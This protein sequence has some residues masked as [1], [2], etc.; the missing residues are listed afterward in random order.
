MTAQS[1]TAQASAYGISMQGGGGENS[2]TIQASA[3]SDDA[4]ALAYGILAFNGSSAVSL[5]NSGTISAEATGDDGWAYGIWADSRSSVSITNSGTIS[6]YG[7]NANI[8]LL[9]SGSGVNRVVNTGTIQTSYDAME[10]SIGIA[11]NGPTE[12]VNTGIIDTG[13]DW[14]G[15]SI[16]A[17][18]TSRLTLGT[19]S[20]LTGYVLLEGDDDI[21][22]LTGEGTEDAM[23]SGVENL[24]MNGTAWTLSGY[25][26]DPFESLTL[27]RGSLTLTQ[28]IEIS[29]SGTLAGSGTLATDVTNNGTVSPGNSIGTLTINGDYTQASTAT[30]RLEAGG[31]TSDLL[32]VTGTADIQGG[33]L[34]LSAAGYLT[35]GTYEFLTAGTLSG[36]FDSLTTPA[37]FEAAL[38]TGSADNLIL[39]VTRSTYVSLATTPE[40]AG[41]GSALDASWPQATEDMADMLTDIDNMAELSSVRSALDDLN[42]RFHSSVTTA[43]LDDALARTDRIRQHLYEAPPQALAQAKGRGRGKNRTGTQEKPWQFWAS[44]AA[45]DRRY[46]GTQGSPKFRA[47]LDGVFFGLDRRVG[48]GLVFGAAGAYSRSDIH[49][50][51]DASSATVDSFDGYL[52]T[53]LNRAG[54]HGEIVA[55]LGQNQYETDRPVPFLGRAASSEHRGWQASALLGGGYDWTP[56]GWT[57][58]P[59]ASV[60]YLHLDENDFTEDGAW[61]ANLHIGSTTSEAWLSSLGFR[62]VRPVL[63]DGKHLV[64][65]SIRAEWLHALSSDTDPISAAFAATG[66][67][68]STSPRDQKEDLL[69]L[70]L[71]LTAVL[72]PKI[73]AGIHYLRLIQGNGGYTAHQAGVG[74]KVLF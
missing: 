10:W 71:S 15:M 14:F 30:M 63:L 70:N 52:Y 7:E 58:G 5:E 16:Y 57:L 17:E 40:Q 38:T 59:V 53:A 62:A 44:G 32:A 26:D 65:P 67:G 60:Q 19:G 39:S 12:I 55:G 42:P 43:T 21:L 41:I 61:G 11:C 18:D 27:Y 45:L 8:G 37:L 68:F 1:E 28:A 64:I 24:L 36:S 51:N 47:R 20:D 72:T 48:T 56:G 6:A 3:S 35:T 66:Q 54:L 23:F 31:G 29:E 73:R 9:V 49:N 4:Q 34:V 25:W 46:D 13:D 50:M 69:K 33:S 2:G 22:E 74:F